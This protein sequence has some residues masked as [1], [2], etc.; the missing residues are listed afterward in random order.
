[1]ELLAP[2]SFEV[3]AILTGLVA[4]AYLSYSKPLNAVYLVTALLPSY[5]I[6][7]TIAGLPS[8]FLE[9]SILILFVSWF[10]KERIWRRLRLPGMPSTGW[11]NPFPPA[12]RLALSLLLVGAFVSMLISPHQPQAFGIFK[13][14]FIEPF[15]FLIV[16]AY[17]VRREADARYC[18][19]ILGG[20]TILMAAVAVWQFDTGMGI[21]NSFWAAAETRRI[22]GFFG[23][24]NANA[25]FAA[26]IAAWFIGWALH[27]KHAA[28]RWF[29]FAVVSAGILI[30]L[31]AKS[32]G[33]LAALGGALIIS[34]YFYKKT[35]AFAAVGVL[36]I[37]AVLFFST[38]ITTIQRTVNNIQQNHL[39]LSSSSLEIRANQ[40]R[41]TASL[42]AAQPFFGS[43]LANYQT[44]LAPYHTYEF[45]EI[46]LYP[47]N[48]ILNF[49][50]ETGLLGLAGAVLLIAACIIML[51]TLLK[52]S[53]RTAHA[54]ALLAAWTA[55]I[56][57]GMVD[58]PYFKNDL[59]ILFMLLAGL[60][61]FITRSSELNSKKTRPAAS[62][63]T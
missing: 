46:Y 29:A 55:L 3:I 41:E 62:T 47:H 53:P 18:M 42:L 34:L 5:L 12:L 19:H 28:E 61:L 31:T 63:N 4:V 37:T 50:T 43:G 6:R 11:E 10:A 54:A 23:Y 48:I 20:L 36:T 57:H 56:I 25:L 38:N 30:I 7:F 58:V 22:T 17:T 32:T 33:A 52:R 14:Y 27:T 24:P 44:A 60:T 13:A 16:F 15:L 59:S 49:W 39:D 1:M 35:I 26:P 8:T 21:P 2:T 9:V 40:W 45:L 51:R